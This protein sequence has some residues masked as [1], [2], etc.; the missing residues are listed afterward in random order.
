V[1]EPWWEHLGSGE[2]FEQKI[3]ERMGRD[4]YAKIFQ[5]QLHFSI[6]ISTSSGACCYNSGRRAV[7]SATLIPLVIASHLHVHRRVP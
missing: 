3:I 5:L 4:F 6:F 1:D 2:E 7:P